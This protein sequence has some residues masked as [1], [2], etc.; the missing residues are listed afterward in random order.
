MSNNKFKKT[1]LTYVKH[2][3]LE[4]E[5]TLQDGNKIK[6]IGPRKVVDD[7][8]VQKHAD[9]NSLMVPIAHIRKA[10]VFAN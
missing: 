6:M 3:G 2:K 7:T 1:I 5:L 8:I 10:E 4:L 9:G